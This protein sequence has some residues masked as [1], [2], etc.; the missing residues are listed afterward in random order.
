M[1]SSAGAAGPWQLMPD[2]A[3]RFAVPITSEFDGRYSLPLATEA[4]LSYLAWL[5]RFFGNDW[6]LGFGRLQRRRR[7]GTQCGFKSGDT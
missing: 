4:A 6:L 5:Y 2:T 7:A 1:V 3:T